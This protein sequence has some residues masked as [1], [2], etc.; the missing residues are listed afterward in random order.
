MNEKNKSAASTAPY[1]AIAITSS[2]CHNSVKNKMSSTC[3]VD[4]NFCKASRKVFQVIEGAHVHDLDH[5]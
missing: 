1:I 3:Y 2:E 5:Y 4:L